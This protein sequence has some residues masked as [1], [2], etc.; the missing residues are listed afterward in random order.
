MWKFE[1]ERIV[2]EIIKRKNRNELGNISFIS[3]YEELLNKKF[4]KEYYKILY[5]VVNSLG[6]QGYTI[7]SL[8]NF[9]IERY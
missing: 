3:L 9:D 5:S 6:K 2:N 4:K 7:V 8:D 1:S